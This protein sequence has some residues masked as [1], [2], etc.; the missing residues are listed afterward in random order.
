MH[1]PL[2]QF[3]CTVCSAA[4]VMSDSLLPYG[5][6]PSRLLCL[7]DSPGKNTGLGCHVLLQGT[8]LRDQPPGIK[9]QSLISSALAHRFF[10]TNATWGAP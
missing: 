9:P 1:D 3:V 8:N 6:Y 7:W 2:F 4:L 10:I 5:L